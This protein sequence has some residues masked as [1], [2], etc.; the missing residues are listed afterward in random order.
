MSVRNVQKSPE[1]MPLPAAQFRRFLILFHV[2]FILG[3]VFTLVLRWR[4]PGFEWSQA[5]YLLVALVGT[6]ITLYLLFFAVLGK[7]ATALNWW[8]SYFGIS[9]GIWLAEWHIENALQWTAWAYLGQM[10]GV[11]RPRVSIPMSLLV[12]ATYYLR[13]FGLQQI[14]LFQGFA[15]ASL[16][17]TVTGLGLFLHRLTATSSERA[18]LIDQL[19]TAKRELEQARE[20]D[21]ELAALRERERLARDLHDSL[22]HSLVTLTVQLEAVQRLYPVDPTRA[23]AVLDQMKELTRTSMEQ[24]RRSLAGL[25][26]PG[27]GD[28]P[29]RQS[30]ETLCRET[31]GQDLHVEYEFGGGLENLPAAVSEA[32]WRTAQEALQNVKRHAKARLARVSLAVSPTS[33]LLTVSDDGVGLSP[34]AQNKPG[35]YGLRGLRERVEGLGGDFTVKSNGTG[36]CLRASIPLVS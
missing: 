31:R 9:F 10:F 5:D 24:L 17:V 18:A 33:A 27:L 30:L 8:V 3:L 19:E 2:I 6:Q 16:V 23:S 14:S 20:R 26:S 4:R 11:L 36:T 7:P 12:F 21:A 34:D 22:G 29:L 25:R 13:S 1:G 35:H 32:L 28:L 15:W